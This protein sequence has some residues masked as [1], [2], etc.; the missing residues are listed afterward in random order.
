MN[1]KIIKAL[2]K[3]EMLDVLRDKK[4]VLMMLIVPLI[5]YPLMII[6][7]LTIM[8]K[9]SADMEEHDYKIGMETENDSLLRML[10]D[11]NNDDKGYSI[12]V[13]SGENLR[14]KLVDG[15]IDA[16]ITMDDSEQKETYVVCYLSADTNS[17]YAADIIIDILNKYSVLITRSLLE[18][19]QLDADYILSPIGYTA[20]DYSSNEESAGNIMGNLIPFMLVT[21]LLMGTMYPAI[22]TTAGEKERGTLET[23][24]TLPV[25][26]RELFF[27]KFL[28]VAT[29]GIVSAVLNILSMGGV[30]IYMYKTILSAGGKTG[31]DLGQF[32]PGIIISGLCVLAFAVFISAVSMCVCVFAGSY[33]EANNYITPLTLVV[34]FASMISLIPSVKLDL[35]MA[36]IPVVNICILI[37]DLLMFKYNISLIVLVLLSNII[38][39]MLAVM[40]LG[41]IY[42]SEAILFGDGTSSVQIFEKRSNMKKGGVPGISDMWLVLM[43]LLVAMIYA[44]GALQLKYGYYGVVGSQL[45]VLLI[46]VLYSAYTKKSMRETFK[47]KSAQ[48]RHIL[49]GVILISG[50]ILVGM[51]ITGITGSIFKNSATELSESMYYLLGDSFLKTLTVAAVIPAVCEEI[52]FRGFVFSALEKRMNYKAAILTGG[53]LFGAYHMNLVQFFTTSFIGMVIC[54]VA[55]RTKSIIPGMIMH[56]VNNAL[57]CITMYYPEKVRKTVPFLVAEKLY[58]RDIILILLIGVILMI[59]GVYIINMKKIQKK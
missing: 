53:L 33:K 7:G 46:P 37:R 17:G 44:G 25:T 10:Q 48:I 23:V 52:M 30:G 59:L 27:S 16:Y 11:E 13:V 20:K 19:T 5:L 43:V 3:K 26:N 41:R 31:I 12:S 29:I 14:Q 6:F 51:I 15:E 8:T 45:M 55:Y 2:Y 22:D 35:N 1:F 4:T 28:T 39:G 49:G 47:L 36:L 54:Y 38:Y 58:L 57:S 50:T 42:S 32:V 18:E 34:M 21:S 56:F 40:L 9:I 24:L